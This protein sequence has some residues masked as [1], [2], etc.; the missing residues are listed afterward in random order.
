MGGKENK[1]ESIRKT[2]SDYYEIKSHS[3]TNGALR[4]NKSKSRRGLRGESRG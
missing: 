4:G 1:M 2:A 3:F